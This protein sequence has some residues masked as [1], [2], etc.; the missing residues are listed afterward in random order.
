MRVRDLQPQASMGPRKPLDAIRLDLHPAAA[1]VAALAPREMRVHVLREEREPCRD[2]L[3]DR[4]EA[5]AMRF[6]RGEPAKT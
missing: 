2:P 6:P 3:D 1:A 5:R 4:D